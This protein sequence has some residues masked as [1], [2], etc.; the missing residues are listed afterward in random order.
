MTYKKEIEA[1]RKRI[2]DIDEQIMKL[3]SERVD[4]S[5]EV[6]RIKRR[7]NK[8]IADPNREAEVYVKT[9]ERA[10]RLKMNP[11]DCVSVFERIVKMCRSLQEGVENEE[12]RQ[13]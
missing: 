3:L 8:P 10:G 12:R 13:S 7:Y 4:A 5:K 2:D 1:L 6:G 11:E 9:R